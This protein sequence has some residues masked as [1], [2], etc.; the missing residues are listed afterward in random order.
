MFTLMEKFEL[1]C[2]GKML[3]RFNECIMIGIN[4]LNGLS[5]SKVWNEISSKWFWNVNWMLLKS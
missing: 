5:V 2:Y 1:H 3:L 4:G